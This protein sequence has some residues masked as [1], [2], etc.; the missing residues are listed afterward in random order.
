M[1]LT[2]T[3]CM[4]Y[5]NDTQSLRSGQFNFGSHLKTPKSSHYYLIHSQKSNCSL[6]ICPVIGFSWVLISLPQW[7]NVMKTG[8]VWQ[9]SCSS[10]ADIKEPQ[11]WDRKQT[12][13]PKPDV[14]L[15]QQEEKQEY[16]VKKFFFHFKNIIHLILSAVYVWGYEGLSKIIA[17]GRWVRSFGKSGKDIHM[18]L[19]SQKALC[20]SVVNSTSN[21]SET[22]ESW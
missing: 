5:G 22:W 13:R 14:G 2:R 1:K 6:R 3:T 21:I 15:K 16:Q 12:F 18:E 20:L 8:R 7:V 10:Q 17:T 19:E 9:G 4:M 11:D